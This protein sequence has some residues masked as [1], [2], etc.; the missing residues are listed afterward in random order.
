MEKSD[1]IK[2]NWE[3]PMIYFLS[4]KSDTTKAMSNGAYEQFSNPNNPGPAPILS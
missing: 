1:K 3:K 2:K 4:I